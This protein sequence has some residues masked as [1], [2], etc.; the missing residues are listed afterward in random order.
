MRYSSGRLLSE[1]TSPCPWPLS[2]IYH[3]LLRLRCQ[4]R[5]LPK[6]AH[7]KSLLPGSIAWF[8]LQ[9]GWHPHASA[10]GWFSPTPFPGL[11]FWLS[12]DSQNRRSSLQR[13]GVPYWIGLPLP[14]S[15]NPP[16]SHPRV[17]SARHASGGEAPLSESHPQALGRG[18]LLSPL[19]ES[20]ARETPGARSVWWVFTS[21]RG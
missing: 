13:F 2:A 3:V 7:I 8:S 5:A 6:P 19:A 17:I 12:D 16:N 20:G 21:K 11:S 4:L 14:A 10:V 18:E 1:R 9:P 15:D